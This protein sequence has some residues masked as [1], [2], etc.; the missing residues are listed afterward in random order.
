MNQYQQITNSSYLA[1][2]NV[3]TISQSYI[4]YTQCI[5]ALA[6]RTHE[7]DTELWVAPLPIMK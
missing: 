3:V 5:S 6:W 1:A 4:G 2:Y 7:R